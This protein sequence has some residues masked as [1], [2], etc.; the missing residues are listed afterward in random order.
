MHDAS[1]R[2]ARAVRRVRRQAAVRRVRCPVAAAVRVPAAV[3]VVG[4]AV[5]A[6]AAAAAAVADAGR[7]IM[8][9]F[10]SID[11]KASPMNNVRLG[12]Y[13]TRLALAL[14]LAV[15]FAASAAPQETFATPEAAVERLWP[16]SRPT[17][18]RP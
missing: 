18:I 6:V 5:V 14:M 12:S 1:A 2:S 11:S 17:A 15:S 16:R 3:A 8:R 10:L 4:A 13:L 7:T 9:T